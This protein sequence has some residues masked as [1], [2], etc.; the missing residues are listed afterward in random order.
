MKLPHLLLF[1]LILTTLTGCLLT[2]HPIYT[3]TDILY[4]QSLVGNYRSTKEQ[5]APL[6]IIQQL[7]A[8]PAALP[9]KV[10]AISN[11]G[12]LLR[13]TNEQG[14]NISE[15]AAFLVKLG[16]N[17]YIDLFPLR[18]RFGNNEFFEAF[19]IPM[20]A[21]YKLDRASAG[22]IHLLPMDQDFIQKLIDQRRLRI[23]YEQTGIGQQNIK[24]ITAPTE[25]LQDFI[26]KYGDQKEAFEHKQI[27]S[28]KK[29]LQ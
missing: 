16:G 3:E 20:H 2:F 5:Q 8:T 7:A 13:Y 24:I 4:E 19:S 18:G 21:I 12:Y 14:N 22:M 23:K 17:T 1:G 25:Q 6:L 9:A 10:K 26:K 29:I 15:Y 11:K 28:Y 27:E